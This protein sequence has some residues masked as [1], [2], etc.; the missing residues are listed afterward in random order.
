M[1]R[2]SESTDS[3]AVGEGELF[4]LPAVSLLAPMRLMVASSAPVGWA[5]SAMAAWTAH[6]AGTGI[7]LT[8]VSG[9]AGWQREWVAAALAPA[10][11]A[12]C[13]AG[14][15][16]LLADEVIHLAQEALAADVRAQPAEPAHE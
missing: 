10:A 11:V 7:I 16:V 1:Q 14:T 8:A 15:P 13:L 3:P 5:L 9:L 2:H 6:V 4:C 12:A